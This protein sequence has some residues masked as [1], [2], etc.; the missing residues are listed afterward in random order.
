MAQGQR[1]QLLNIQKMMIGFSSFAT[2][3][4]LSMA[5]VGHC[6]QDNDLFVAG[7]LGSLFNTAALGVA[8]NGYLKKE[9]N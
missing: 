4:T 3:F 9:R 2:I 5:E 1:K 6:K 8:M 7:T